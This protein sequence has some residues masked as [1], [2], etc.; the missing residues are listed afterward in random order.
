[1]KIEVYDP[2]KAVTTLRLRLVK[3]TDKDNHADLVAVDEAGHTISKLCR[4]GPTGLYR[5]PS[6]SPSLGLPLD[7][8]GRV[9]FCE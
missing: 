2:A 5:Y 7:M 1:M 6:V 4:I 9:K 3:T 8:Y